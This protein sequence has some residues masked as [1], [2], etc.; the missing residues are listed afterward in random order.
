MI[1]ERKPKILV[2][3]DDLVIRHYLNIALETEGFT[4]LSVPT[5][6]AGYQ[7]LNAAQVDVVV[8]NVVLEAENGLD[9]ARK[10]IEEHPKIAVII[11]TGIPL[12]DPTLQQDVQKLGCVCIS[13]T[14]PVDELLGAIHT[15]LKRPK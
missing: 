11:L 14:A 8:L 7:V 9:V 4:V 13:K 1:R 6:H 15:A 3:D 10:I 5:G 2:V 12:N